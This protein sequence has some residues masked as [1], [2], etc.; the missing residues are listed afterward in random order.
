MIASFLVRLEF[1]IRKI[2]L[3]NQVAKGLRIHR[4]GVL[5][6]R[7]EPFLYIGNVLLKSALHFGKE[8]C[9]F[10]DEAR[11]KPIEKAQQVVCNQNLTVAS[12]PCADADYRNGES[13][14]YQL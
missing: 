14:G 10:F 1:P 7:E 11:R 9:V 3:T 12:V 2:N 6:S 13:L 5:C 4:I 8:V